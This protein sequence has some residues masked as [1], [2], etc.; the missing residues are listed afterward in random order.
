MV[1]PA[2]L[3]HVGHAQPLRSF[4]S[5]QCSRIVILDPEEIWFSE[6]LQG[7][8]LLMA[9]RKRARTEN[10]AD[11]AIVPIRTR[12]EL[13]CDPE[14]LF[15]RVGCSNACISKEKWMALF[16]DREEL[17]LLAQLRSHP[18]VRTF[19]ELAS[20]DV[21]IVTGANQFFLVN[22][23]T[24]QEFELEPWSHAMF[25]RSEHVQGIVFSTA[26]HE[27]NRRAGLRANFLWFQEENIDKLPEKVRLYLRGGVEAKLDRRYKCRVR[28]P[29]Y[30]VPSVYTAPIAMLK[31]AHHYPRLILNSA[32]AYS[33]DTAYRIRPNNAPAEAL[34]LNFVNSLTCLTAELEGRHYGGGVLELVP[35][36]IERLLLPL[37]ECSPEQLAA[38]DAEYRRTRDPGAFLRTRDRMVLGALRL[39]RREEAILF[40]A[41]CKLHDRRQRLPSALSDPE[42]K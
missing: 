4:L 38:A 25:G 15:Q 1:V 18:R 36:E 23:Q 9:E 34:V 6:T 39:S 37:L 30:K 16:L 29:W 3:L 14:E 11:I 2:E 26:D 42:I 41:W 17:A 8:V 28:R 10:A 13:T 40:G 31:R 5:E 21:G 24:V 32:R 35:S 20:V 27:A 12:A 19:K 22:D 33:T 7:T